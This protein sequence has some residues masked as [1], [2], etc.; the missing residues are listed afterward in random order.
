MLMLLFF[1]GRRIINDLL[2]HWLGR[3]LTIKKRRRQ[4]RGGASFHL[5]PPY[6]L[7]WCS[8]RWQPPSPLIRRGQ[9]RRG[10]PCSLGTV[11]TNCSNGDAPLIDLF[12]TA[13][14]LYCINQIS[15]N[16]TAKSHSFEH[17]ATY[18]IMKVLTDACWISSQTC[19][20]MGSLQGSNEAAAPQIPPRTLL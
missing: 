20:Q 18:S 9:L 14:S 6:C 8:D 13:L 17:N 1:W 19:I 7:K 5:R 4:I 15:I 16:L 11:L 2:G 10:Q 3:K 12:Q